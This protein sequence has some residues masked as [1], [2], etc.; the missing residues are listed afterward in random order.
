[1]LGGIVQ[2]VAEHLLQ[3][4]RVAGNGRQLVVAGHIVEL[5]ALLPEQLPV[6]KNRVLEFR[7]KIHVLQLQGEAAVLHLGKLQQLLHHVGEPAGLPQDDPHA[8]AQLLGVAAVIGQQRFAPAVDG[9]EGRAQLVGHGGDE[10]R[11]HLFALADLQ[12]HLV[13]VVHQLPHFV[14]IFIGNLDAVAAAGDTLGGLRHVRHGRGDLPHKG[15]VHRQHHA[16]DDHGDA[17]DGQR[18]QHYLP[19][20]VAGGRHQTH[21]AHHAAIIP[22]RRRDRQ[23]TLP[24]Q[25]VFTGIGLHFAAVQGAAHLRSFRREADSLAAAGAVD[26]AAPV[27][28]LQLDSLR[29]V[30]VAGV[31]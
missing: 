21:G 8:A 23:N 15:Q 4:L 6:G 12:G 5:N 9:R 29:A 16:A 28:K 2:H 22:Q 19:V 25:G 17:H 31:E 30:E 18:Q 27:Q 24:R 1:M 10:L 3:P 20:K 14:V 26:A 11:L 13:D 7:L